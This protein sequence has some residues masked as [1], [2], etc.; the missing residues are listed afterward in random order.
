MPCHGDCVRGKN[1]IEAVRV[2]HDWARTGDSTGCHRAGMRRLSNRIANGARA[3]LGPG[4]GHG[5]GEGHAIQHR[6][7][8][9]GWRLDIG[10][11]SYGQ[12]S[13]AHAVAW[14]RLRQRL[15]P[16]LMASISA[17]YRHSYPFG[18]MINCRR[19]SVSSM[20]ARIFATTLTPNTVAPC[21]RSPAI[22]PGRCSTRRRCPLLRDEY[23]CAVRPK[24]RA[25]TLEDSVNKMQ[26][27][28]PAG[29][30]KTVQE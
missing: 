28:N 5:Q 19:A 9:F 12:W 7:T 24:V 30:L 1:G 13:G 15:R 16:M 20:K 29:F 21:W 25:D 14:E 8:A 26:D 3:I 10:A 11:Q 6:R 18:L 17:G 23:K 4:L 27:V 22:T 2:L